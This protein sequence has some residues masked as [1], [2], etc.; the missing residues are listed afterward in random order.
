M[1]YEDEQVYVKLN[2]RMVDIM[3][4]IEARKSEEF[5]EYRSLQHEKTN[6]VMSGRA[7]ADRLREIEIGLKQELEEHKDKLAELSIDSQSVRNAMVDLNKR[8]E[9]IEMA[10][11]VPNLPS[12]REYEKVS[13]P[14]ND[15]AANMLLLITTLSEKYGLPPELR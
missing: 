7:N 13:R 14:F 6:M 12:A 1:Y 4:V 3:A 5:N 9:A 15:C 10:M 11:N 2:T 8:F